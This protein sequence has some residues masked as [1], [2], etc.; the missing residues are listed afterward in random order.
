[1]YAN[2]TV[3]S[4]RPWATSPIPHKTLVVARG[5]S[6]SLHGP[7]YRSRLDQVGDRGTD[8]CHRSHCSQHVANVLFQLGLC[9]KC[10]TVYGRVH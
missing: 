2:L 6:F 7:D 9:A 1:M 4:R 8:I 5:T 3:T 10:M